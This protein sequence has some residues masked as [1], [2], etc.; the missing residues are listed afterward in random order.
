MVDDL[1]AVLTKLVAQ[2]PA[3]Q[4]RLVGNMQQ[5]AGGGVSAINRHAQNSTN[6][7]GTSAAVP[8]R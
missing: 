4:Q 8:R 1:D 5:Q 3:D 6:T 7:L 2:S